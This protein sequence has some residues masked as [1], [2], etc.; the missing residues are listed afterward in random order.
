MN[1][2]IDG[3]WQS[4]YVPEAQDFTG[5]AEDSRA[6]CHELFLGKP[7][8]KFS[9]DGKDHEIFSWCCRMNAMR[10]EMKDKYFRWKPLLDKE[11]DKEG[12]KMYLAQRGGETVYVPR[13]DLEKV[14]ALANTG[15]KP[16][17]RTPE[18]KL[19]PIEDSMALLSTGRILRIVAPGEYYDGPEFKFLSNRHPSPAD[20]F[21]R[22]LATEYMMNV[23]I[24]NA[25]LARDYGFSVGGETAMA[26]LDYCMR[27]G[28]KRESVAH[29][30]AYLAREDQSEQTRLFSFYVDGVKSDGTP[31]EAD[32]RCFFKK[33]VDLKI[34]DAKPRRKSRTE[35]A[36]DA[37]LERMKKEPELRTISHRKLMESG[38]SNRVARMFMKVREDA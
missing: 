4:F 11:G 17:E 32:H 2:K 1:T 14:L 31:V 25:L 20:K 21:I 8:T 3:V 29:W 36:V 5:V 15:E 33:F 24:P 26:A 28:K 37:L 18:R 27:T 16:A 38:I 6:K 12:T 22:R 30:E 7:S 9:Y 34:K 10:K 35:S 23:I 19:K 13:E